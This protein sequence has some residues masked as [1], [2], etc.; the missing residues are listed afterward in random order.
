MRLAKWEPFSDA[1][2]FFRQFGTSMFGR[3]PLPGYNSG[4]VKE[5]TPAADISETD[6]EYLVKAEIP[7]VKPADIKVSLDKGV[8]SIEG[9]RKYEMEDKNEK[10]HR[11]ERFYG[12][13]NR[14]FVL[15]DDADATAIRAEGREG[16]LT[17]HLPKKVAAPTLGPKQIKVE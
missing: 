5:W 12:G 3:L 8:L 6:R 2:D 11:I 15:P 16:V 1:D 7:G 10:S 14:R 17:I 13:F 9:E 4:E